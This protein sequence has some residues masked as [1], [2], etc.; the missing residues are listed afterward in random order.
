MP[1]RYLLILLGIVFTT[2]AF[3]DCRGPESLA[4]ADVTYQSASLTWSYFS[5]DPSFKFQVQW[6]AAGST[7]W[8][9]SPVLTAYSTSLTNL[10]NNT[11]Y[12]WRAR[13]ICAAGD[14]SVFIN[15]IPFLTK[16]ATPYTRNVTNITHQSAQLSWYQPVSGA[17]SE[18]YWRAAGEPNWTIVSGLTTDFLNLAGLPEETSFEWQV[19]TICSA[20]ESSDFLIGSSFRTRCL[21][22]TNARTKGINPDAVELAWDSPTTNV[23]SDIQWRRAGTSAWTVVENIGST[24]YTLAGLANSTT[25]E[26]QV[27]TACSS[28]DKS[29]FT[30]IQLV[31]TSCPLP[32]D[33][34]TRS[35]SYNSAVLEWKTFAGELQ[36]RAAGTATWN[37]VS[38][39]QSPYSL[40]GLTNNTTYEW[41]V[42]TVC[43]PSVSSAF[44]P[45]QLITTRCTAPTYTFTSTSQS[46]GL[47]LTWNSPSGNLS[48][49]Q[50]RIVG[51]TSW[52]SVTGVT[53]NNYLLTGL[54]AG[55]TYEWRVR[56]QCS[57]TE[58]SNF[59]MAQPYTLYCLAPGSLRTE[60]ATRTAI[61]LVWDSQGGATTYE[62]QWRSVGAAGW[63]SS[64]VTTTRYKLTELQLGT[65]YEW[66]VR[67][68][69]SSTALSDFTS[70]RTFS[71]QCANPS[72]LYVGAV[73]ISSALVS[74][75]GFGSRPPYELQYRIQGATDWTSVTSLTATIF[76]LTGLAFNTTYEW[77]VGSGCSI[78][79]SSVQIFKTQ[80]A[81]P[82]DPV[83]STINFN[84]VRLTWQSSKN[85]LTEIQYRETGA[86]TWISVV[87]KGN[88]PIFEDGSWS[89]NQSYSLYNLPIG[90]TYEWR[91][92]TQCTTSI[93]SDFVNG[94]PFSSDC[95]APVPLNAVQQSTT[96]LRIFWYASAL[97][98][99]YD[100]QWRSVGSPVWNEVN[101]ITGSS[102][103]LTN[104]TNGL[105]YQYRLRQ[106]CSAGVVSDYS[107]TFTATLGCIAH[108]VPDQTLLPNTAVQLNFDWSNS[109]YNADL[110]NELQ[111]RN[112]TSGAWTTISGITGTT[113]SLTGLTPNTTYEWRVR[114]QCSP[115]VFSDFS[116]SSSFVWTCSPPQPTGSSVNANS[117][118]LRWRNYS[119]YMPS[120]VVQWRVVG[121]TN[122]SSVTVPGDRLEMVYSLTGLANNTVY[123]WRV[124]TDCGN[125]NLS[126]FSAPV[127]FQTACPAVT[128]IGYSYPGYNTA[129]LN[130]PTVNLSVGQTYTVQYRIAG[131]VIWSELTG[132]T[133]GNA[134]IT[135]LAGNTNYEWRIKTYCG[136]SG[137]ALFSQTG[138]FTTQCQNPANVNVSDLTSRSFLISW[139]NRADNTAVNLLVRSLA[140]NGSWV[141][142]ISVNGLTSSA[143]LVTNLTPG[144]TYDFQVRGVCD[145]NTLADN[146][147]YSNPITTPGSQSALNIGVDSM[148]YQ[149]ARLNWSDGPESTNYVLQWRTRN[150]SWNTTGSLST[151]RYLLMGLTPNTTYDVRVSYVD[152]AGVAHEASTSFVTTCL[153]PSNLS[154]TQIRSNSA[155]LSWVTL[156]W[157]VTIQWR[158]AGVS[159][160]QSVTGITSNTYSLTGLTNYTIYEWRVVT[161]CS[162]NVMS[163]SS[164][165]LFRTIC[166]MPTSTETRNEATQSAQLSWIGSGSI[167]S[168]RYRVIGET[169]WTTLS[170]ITSTTYSLTGL[171]NNTDYEWAVTT[172]CEPT[173][174]SLYT[175][176][177]RFKTQCKPPTNLRS[178]GGKPNRTYLK[179]DGGES[180][181]Q[182]DWRPVGSSSWTTIPDATSPYLLTGL[183]NDTSYEWRVRGVCAGSLSAPAEFLVHCYYDGYEYKYQPDVTANSAQLN[184]SS[185]NYPLYD[186]RW[187]KLGDSNWTNVAGI[188][189]L[190]YKLTSLANNTVY[191]WQIRSDCQTDFGTSAFFLTRCGS[192][193]RLWTENLSTTSI[194]FRW[195]ESGDGVGYQLRW[196]A[197]GSSDWNTISNI[198][199]TRFLLTNLT[200]NTSYE[201]QVS[202]QCGDETNFQL[203]AFFK[204]LNNCPF[205]LHTLRDGSWDDP[206]VWSCNRVPD[207]A[208]LVEVNHVVNVPA[209]QTAKALTIRYGEAARITFGSGATLRLK[210]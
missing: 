65:T 56:S 175:S 61:D 58:Y 138:T 14:T 171:M 141:N 86:A 45:A 17:T 101:G 209:N 119:P 103:D 48:E 203:T 4:A 153:Y 71:L 123:E 207:F 165:A 2:S 158:V 161:R 160:W 23:S 133:S 52:S 164:T 111:Y 126:D 59:L 77:R 122:W 185:D 186:L 120:Y 107:S 168:I 151:K 124:A 194:L 39:V 174:S 113:Y 177:T 68:A 36:W 34:S 47:Y 98:T 80:C 91:I 89:S 32:T 40:S 55:A 102:Y 187:R 41:R 128:Y 67:S 146:S 69:C 114:K 108:Y 152:N 92:R 106:A 35:V 200:N 30:D 82:V 93:Y 197:V 81:T 155:Q 144:A 85:N 75:D 95:P 178:A 1:F 116:V 162:D 189:T 210:P 157:P 19:R 6:R 109:V 143:Y 149:T 26:W 24:E 199:E 49:I 112:N 117:A 202:S 127:S 166:Q 182:I 79:F 3:A 33:V 7:G 134:L 135:G 188:T 63:L 191:E 96:S 42:R 54:Q 131:R 5:G 179:W 97:P 60:N 76:S 27:R 84:A 50:W 70:S 12:E 21:P 183:T 140:E 28:T 121:A 132:I 22:P 180:T 9:T 11:A 206:T 137:A 181:Y 44:T 139:T 31:Q 37:V 8:T 167:Y 51:A 184:W 198:N 193:N 15:G 43:S 38:N 192:T 110:V 172:V 115:T 176:P 148:S 100:L 163:P 73:D 136:E 159:N 118:T 104:L 53:G 94:Q 16:C 64:T 46:N 201:W 20:T 74:W 170:G 147:G 29:T 10:T 130:W 154:T 190:P 66:R 195:N 105:N 169:T 18:V 125:G 129:Q 142:T 156:G 90:K 99:E 205:G 88:E 145:V 72:H 83:V 13:T 173:T 57:D 87:T 62:V 204:T 150:G 196:R 208:D 25:Y 78:D